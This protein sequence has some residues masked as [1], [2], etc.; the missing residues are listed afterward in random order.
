[1]QKVAGLALRAVNA[2][3]QILTSASCFSG[4]T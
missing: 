1:M 3:K 2:E 4:L